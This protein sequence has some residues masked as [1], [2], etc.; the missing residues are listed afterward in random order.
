MSLL[1]FTRCPETGGNLE[2]AQDVEPRGS[3]K[4]PG[5]GDPQDLNFLP[6]LVHKYADWFSAWL[7]GIK[8]EAVKLEA[9]N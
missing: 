8:A 3:G 6:P 2:E 9:K 4:N 5:P 7:V 1:T